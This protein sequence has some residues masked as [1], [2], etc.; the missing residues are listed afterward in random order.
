MASS[1]TQVSFQILDVLQGPPNKPLYYRIEAG[2]SVRYLAASKPRSGLPDTP[3]QD[4][5]FDAVPTR[6]WNMA[7]LVPSTD[8]KFALASTEKKSLPNATP[9]WHVLSI[10]FLELGPIDYDNNDHIQLR[11]HI[12][13]GIFSNPRGLGAAKVAAFWILNLT[14]D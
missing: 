11:G 5:G 8:G 6:D 9:I 12:P 3:G 2:S 10:D 7:S 4:L 14:G 13:P 1:P